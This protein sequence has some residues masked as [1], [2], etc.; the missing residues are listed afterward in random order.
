MW[1]W[2]DGELVID[3]VVN[4]YLRDNAKDAEYSRV[5]IMYAW[6][7]TSFKT[8]LDDIRITPPS[9]DEY[10][11]FEPEREIIAP[12][13]EL[14]DFEDLATDTLV[15]DTVLNDGLAGDGF[16]FTL[17]GS[18][19]IT[20][21]ADPKD[22][23]NKVIYNVYKGIFFNF[24]ESFDNY[25]ELELSFDVMF[26]GM[27]GH[28]S[29]LA[30]FVNNESKAFLRIHND[31][32]AIRDNGESKIANLAQGADA[33]W[34]T[35]VI[36]IDPATGAVDFKITD[37]DSGEAVG[38]K[39]WKVEAFKTV[40]DSG[41]A[42][43]LKLHHCWNSSFKSYFDNIAVKATPAAGNIIPVDTSWDINDGTLAGKGGVSVTAGSG[44]DFGA[45]EGDTV[46][47]S[48]ALR[49]MKAT[50][51]S[52]VTGPTFTLPGIVYDY[53]EIT[54]SYK[55]KVNYTSNYVNMFR[56]IKSDG[57]T[58]NLFRL[59]EMA[60]SDGSSASMNLLSNTGTSAGKLTNGTWSTVTVTV[61]PY[62]N[63]IAVKVD[64]Q[65]VVNCDGNSSI[66]TIFDDLNSVN[67]PFAFMLYFHVDVMA[68]LYYDDISIKATVA[69][70]NAEAVVDGLWKDD[71]FDMGVSYDVG[72]MANDDW[73]IATDP[74]L[75]APN[76]FWDF[77]DGNDLA[78]Q[79]GIL[80]SKMSNLTVAA[81]EGDTVNTTK[82]IGT[83]ANKTSGDFGK[84]TFP[85]TIND[86]ET[87][88]VSLKFR[89]DHADNY[90][91]M[92]R[93]YKAD[94][95]NFNVLRVGK[96]QNDATQC[97][98]K[99]WGNN[100]GGVG[101][102]SNLTTLTKGKWVEASI[103]ITPAN[104][105]VTVTVDG[106]SVTSTRGEITA[107]RDQNKQFVFHIYAHSM[108]TGLDT[109]IYFD[110]IEIETKYSWEYKS[111]LGYNNN[112][113][114]KT[115]AD[116]SGNIHGIFAIE[117]KELYLANQPFEI[118]FDYFLNQLPSPNTGWL[119]LVKLNM[120][121]TQFTIFRLGPDGTVY[122][123]TSAAYINSTSGGNL[124]LNVASKKLAVG[125]WY[126]IRFAFDP[127]SGHV[128]GYVDNAL[129]C[130]YNINDVYTDA[131]GAS[132]G[133]TKNPDRM[134]IELSSQYVSSIKIND[135]CFDNL[136]IRTLGYNEVS[137]G[138]FADA[139]F[140]GA[141]L[142]ALDANGLAKATGLYVTELAGSVSVAGTDVAKYIDATVKQGDG[143]GIKSV[144]G[145]APFACDVVALEG[146]FTF[147]S[148]PDNG[149]LNLYSFR[150]WNGDGWDST[151]I[152]SL[153]SDGSLL[154]A[155]GESGHILDEN[156][157]Y[158][159][160][161]LFSTASGTAELYVDG[162][163][164]VAA[165]VAPQD[166][167]Y[168]S[169]YNRKFITVE[170]AELKTLS[171]VAVQYAE[172][173]DLADCVGFDAMLDMLTVEG[174]GTWGVKLDDISIYNDGAANFYA[175]TVTDNLSFYDAGNTLW[176]KDYIAEFNYA[177]NASEL[178][179]LAEWTLAADNGED[180]PNGLALALAKVN[181]TKLYAAD[182]TTELATVAEGDSI[183]IAVSTKWWESPI[184]A[185]NYPVE[186]TAY[187]NGQVAGY[188]KVANVTLPESRQLVFAEGTSDVKIYYGN[189]VRDNRTM[190]DT[191]GVKFDGYNAFFTDFEDEDFFATLEKNAVNY[192]DWLY[193]VSG[194]KVNDYEDASVIISEY[195]KDEDNSFYRI[196]RP[197]VDNKAPAYMEYNLGAMG[198]YKKLYSVSLDLRF[199]DNLSNSLNI[200]TIYEKNMTGE[201]ELLLVDY[202]NKLY[203]ENNGVRYYLCNGS[204]ENLKVNR[205]SDES[206][207]RVAL[208]VNEEQ[209]TY[210]VWVDGQCAWYYEDGH[211]SG[212]PARANAIPLNYR[213]IESYTSCDPKIR[214]FEATTNTGS[215]TV[216]DIDNISIDVIKNGYAPVNVSY[217]TNEL[218][219]AV[220]F[221]ATVDTL[222]TNEVGFEVVAVSNIDGTKTYS[223]STNVVFSSIEAD[224]ETVSAETIGGRYVSVLAIKDLRVAE[225]TFTVKPFAVIGG[226]RIYGA[227]SVYEYSFT[228][229]VE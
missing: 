30:P 32:S 37:R 66:K 27:G 201:L 223:D 61:K 224:G 128:M 86:Y 117:D 188:Y 40:H 94:G 213:E 222:Y 4:N 193:P 153:C 76:A 121:G 5:G 166:R 125:Q 23:T 22:S 119:N 161:L 52:N 163:F 45:V 135:C 20:A 88:K 38:S 162:E 196:R 113:V 208:V 19:S 190:S 8:D 210:A 131:N 85:G 151:P 183:A 182:G 111:S 84:L 97:G 157:V 177:G 95:S 78:A 176:G 226:E 71:S 65:D 132:I 31:T 139:D 1:L 212:N 29:F 26:E 69:P 138:V 229:S 170:D 137:R 34:Y 149:T 165:P 116:D 209:G 120:N 220:R 36:K 18:G 46:N 181:G 123:Y 101:D 15:S 140:N 110:D 184:A 225:Y 218:G 203:F 199:T 204:G 136:R 126:N 144:V 74:K 112:K 42:L 219:D 50:E 17:D 21:V 6:G 175:D 13:N 171:G 3:G 91:N 12:I 122:N 118:S 108:G 2:L 89:H 174:D 100:P 57:G 80:T 73:T 228:T 169:A 99:A 102:S 67:K 43:K 200:A 44:Y 16:V 227:E 7:G 81:I 172:M 77:E 141:A 143:I 168:G 217:Q 114:L 124:P 82:V 39:A 185:D 198:E 63:K 41:E 75:V 35:M 33:K 211:E 214:L 189:M 83:I 147:S 216:A 87:I 79:N 98:I 59:S 105:N 10:I 25:S 215:D 51:K 60:N 179:A 180:Y 187:V 53:S 93:I 194:S 14:L 115:A 158:G 142:G 221:V 54:V 49:I 47:T 148:M 192:V 9:V 156:R 146:N 28:A 155:G 70:I 133:V 64:G 134:Q 55:V 159:I 72:N 164:T 11:D 150:F 154:L 202:Q 197:E 90:L 68:E 130:D 58:Q 24:L 186:V 92:F 167:V 104:G 62:Q 56:F 127:N 96:I 205:V 206:F 103:V 145:G 152:L 207:T 48:G 195:V 129:A 106:K 160:K 107:L 191:S 173:P 109:A 178:T